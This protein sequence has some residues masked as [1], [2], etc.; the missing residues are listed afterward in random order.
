MAVEI[1]RQELRAAR[2]DEYIVLMDDY[3]AELH[4][5]I[6]VT[7]TAD[8]RAAE[9]AA[10]TAAHAATQAQLEAYASAAKQDLTQQKASG[11][12]LRLKTQQRY[13][14]AKAS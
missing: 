3:G 2:R 13:G 7:F 8:Q 10:K 12:A 6:P 1:A 4:V 5:V 9:I 14:L 11:Q